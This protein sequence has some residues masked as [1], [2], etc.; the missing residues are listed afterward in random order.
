MKIVNLYSDGKTVAWWHVPGWIYHSSPGTI[1][2][3][4]EAGQP[5]VVHGTYTI[6]EVS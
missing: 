3:D 4:D 6:Q 2:F 1:E 5:V